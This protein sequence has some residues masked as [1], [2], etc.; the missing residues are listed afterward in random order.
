MGGI[1]TDLVNYVP[2]M[3][4]AMYKVRG[5][6]KLTIKALQIVKITIQQ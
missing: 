3:Y 4:K 1:P 5:T 6:T 2:A